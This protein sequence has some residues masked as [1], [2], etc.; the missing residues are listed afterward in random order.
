MPCRTQTSRWLIAVS[1]LVG[2][3]LVMTGCGSKSKNHAAVTTTVPVTSTTPTTLSPRDAAIT[4][5]YRQFWAAYVAAGDPVD[6]TAPALA[7]H[8]TGKE[9]TAVQQN[10]TARKHA[11]QVLKGTLD[12]AP[13][14]TQSSD[15]TATVR[16]CYADHG[17]VFDAT[18]G[19][20]VDNTPDVVNELVVATL[21]NEQGVWK[22][23]D[24]DHQGSGCTPDARS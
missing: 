17:H 5:A 9:L 11:N 20:Q 13:R 10:F 21:T 1:T 18:T 23:S 7:A 3:A 2:V 24:V 22:V 15:T 8:A 16:D 6:P 4:D 14:V 19:K 12:L